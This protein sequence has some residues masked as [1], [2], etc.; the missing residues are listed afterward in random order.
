MIDQSYTPFRERRATDRHRSV[1]TA[2]KIVFD[3]RDHFCLVRNVSAGGL[4]IEMRRPP[5]T[6]RRVQIETAGLNPCRATVIWSEDRLV[7]LEFEQ[8]Q[9][10]DIV[11]RRGV[12]D[13]GLIV[14]GPRFRCN[15]IAEFIADDRSCIVEVVNISVGGA[16]LRG[17]SGIG[18]NA[19]GRLVMGKP[20]PPLAGSV[21]WRVGEDIGF[22]FADA[23]SRDMMAVL[24]N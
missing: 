24:L 12:A 6:G 7:G 10:V 18:I 14:R 9:N 15:R 8:P 17:V 5:R 20:M 19:S 21:R 13:A 2:G 23:L 3:G 4:M 22:K 1:L 16:K 11:C